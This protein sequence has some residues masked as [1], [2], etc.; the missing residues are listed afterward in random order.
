[1]ESTDQDGI[2]NFA[3]GRACTVESTGEIQKITMPG[4]FQRDSNLMSLLKSV[5]GNIFKSLQKFLISI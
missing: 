2:V 5:L 1:M 4:F 3:K